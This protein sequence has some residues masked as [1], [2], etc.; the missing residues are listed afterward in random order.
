MRRRAFI[1]LLAGAAAVRSFTA[2]AQ[3]AD[4][5]RRCV[6]GIQRNRS[7]GKGVALRV[8]A[9]A[10]GV[11]LDRGFATCGWMFVGHLAVRM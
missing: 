1:T 10:F 3:H 6:D 7:R 4:R 5:L 11:G 9:R 2:T 8:H